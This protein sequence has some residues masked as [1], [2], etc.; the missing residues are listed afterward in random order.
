[1]TVIEKIKENHLH[2]VSI[3]YGIDKLHFRCSCFTTGKSD[4][5]S[6]KFIHISFKRL[7]KYF[8]ILLSFLYKWRKHEKKS[9]EKNEKKSFL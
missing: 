3:F 9:Y 7:F 6:Y 5:L 8:I 2:I 4:W 1:M